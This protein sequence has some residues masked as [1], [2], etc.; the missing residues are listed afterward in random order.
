M[1]QRPS[2]NPITGAGYSAGPSTPSSYS[3]VRRSS[4]IPGMS[5][6]SPAAGSAPAVRRSSNIPGLGDGGPTPVA[7]TSTK[8]AVVAPWDAPAGALPP[9]RQSNIVSSNP[10]SGDGV[11]STPT[12]GKGQSAV[13]RN[14]DAPFGVAKP[15]QTEG[16]SAE[17]MKLERRRAS[18]IPRALAEKPTP[19]HNT[20]SF[21]LLTGASNPGQPEPK[22]FE[23]YLAN[24]KTMIMGASR[25]KTDTPRKGSLFNDSEPPPPSPAPRP[26]LVD[27]NKSSIDFG[28]PAELPQTKTRQGSLS[29]NASSGVAASVFSD[30]ETGAPPEDKPRGKAI[31]AGA[32]KR[33]EEAPEI[34]RA[35]SR[36]NE[37]ALS[38]GLTPAVVPPEP[39]PSKR[40]PPDTKVKQSTALPTGGDTKFVDP[41]T[42]EKTIERG[43]TSAHLGHGRGKKHVQPPPSSIEAQ[44][45][46]QPVSKI[47]A[48]VG[49]P[50][51]TT[52]VASPT[53]APAPPAPGGAKAPPPPPR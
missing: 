44:K 38:T 41:R 25:A 43:G 17:Q 5:D 27:K 30:T 39:A 31:V 46:F 4:G 8:S 42:E 47:A 22:G 20:S 35:P 49:P 7:A 13:R 18:D 11:V 51:T 36:V 40:P 53:P 1:A 48:P 15:G 34:K 26:T 19:N 14:S 50:A 37:S 33:S 21:N 3:G 28:A 52:A 23:V 29:R 24:G 32:T 6:P 9:R 2:T 12:A 45:L 16:R 10:I